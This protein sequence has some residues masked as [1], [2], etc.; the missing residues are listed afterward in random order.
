MFLQD[1][2]F[3]RPIPPCTD[4][5]T[6]SVFHISLLFMYLN[7]L[8]DDHL[9]YLDLIVLLSFQATDALADP[10]TGAAALAGARFG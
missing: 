5:G 7:K 10:T 2:D 9:P 8:L 6:Q 1:L 3:G 4:V